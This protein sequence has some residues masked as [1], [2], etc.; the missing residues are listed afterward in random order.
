MSIKKL[1]I[2]LYLFCASVD[3]LSIGRVN[4]TRFTSVI[5]TNDNSIWLSNFTTWTEC[6]C[7]ILSNDF[8]S[9]IAFNI[10]LNGSCQLFL[11]L[12]IT[13]RLERNINSTLILLKPLPEPNLA[14]CCSNLSWLMAR[15]NISQSAWASINQPSFLIIDDNDFLVALSYKG[16]LV[17]FN[18]TTL[19]PIRTKTI[20]G[21]ATGLSYRNGFYYIRKCNYCHLFHFLINHSSFYF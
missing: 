21:D 13:Y 12:P 5:N 15:I 2:A 17:Q 16:P 14:P 18:R 4:Q 20:G 8:S 9:T 11:T 19:A 1:I 6:L 7:A 3:C 10:Y